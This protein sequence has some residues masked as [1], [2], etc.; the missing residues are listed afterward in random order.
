MATLKQYRKDNAL[1]LS[2]M[3]TRT[4]I[5]AASLSRLENGL[6][7]PSAFVAKT[8]LKA[9]KGKVTPSDFLTEDKSK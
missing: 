2:D 5:S 1:T 3:E 7:W 6:Q 8:I 4:G 9:T